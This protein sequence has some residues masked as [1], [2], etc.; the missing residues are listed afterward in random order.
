MPHR[1]G[2][3]VSHEAAA[4]ACGRPIIRPVDCKTRC[5]APAFLALVKAAPAQ[6]PSPHP[7]TQTAKLREARGDLQ[8]AQRA[9]QAASRG[10]QGPLRQLERAASKREALEEEARQLQEALGQAESRLKDLRNERK[11]MKKLLDK[12]VVPLMK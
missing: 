7:A 8:K 12:P 11:D 2:S 6:L 10:V 3:H 9:A 5:S 1:D 4:F